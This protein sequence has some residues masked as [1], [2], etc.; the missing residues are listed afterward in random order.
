MDDPK[1]P[2][3]WSKHSVENKNK[4]TKRPFPEEAEPE[5]KKKGKKVKDAKVAE[6]LESHKGDVLFEEFMEAHLPE[7]KQLWQQDPE[8]KDGAEDEGKEADKV[9]S[10]LEYL[11]LKKKKNTCT[12]SDAND[13]GIVESEHVHLDRLSVKLSNLPCT[14]KKGDIKEFLK[15]AKTTSVRIPVKMKGIAYCDFSSE[16]EFKK[17]LVKNRS[18][19]GKFV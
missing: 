6:L 16:S 9:I 14:V 8:E 7:K 2:R 13:S 5:K 17:A 4:T 3:A 11:K 12:P 10:D 15:P 1:K 18:F 19:I